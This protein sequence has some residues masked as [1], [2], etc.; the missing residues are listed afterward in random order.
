MPFTF[1]SPIT[2]A[3]AYKKTHRRKSAS[4]PLLSPKSRNSSTAGSTSTSLFSKLTNRIGNLTRGSGS[5]SSTI[6]SNVQSSTPTPASDS[7]F[8]LLPLPT[9]QK[10]YGYVIGRQEVLHILLKHKPSAQAHGCSIAYRRCRAH[11]HIDD[12]VASTCREFLDIADGAYFGSF[13]H[14]GGLLL[15]C[16]DM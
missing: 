15:T 11:G 6:D 4:S 9:R 10:I 16:R 5:P 14:A 13:D 7:L 8:F 2:T 3:S 1:D 12:C